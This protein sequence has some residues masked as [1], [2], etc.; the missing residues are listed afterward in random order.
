ML[1]SKLKSLPLAALAAALFLLPA[2]RAEAWQYV[3]LENRGAFLASLIVVYG[4]DERRDNRLPNWAETWT[5]DAIGGASA[6]R[7][8]GDEILTH[9]FP[10]MTHPAKVEGFVHDVV[11]DGLVRTARAGFP[12]LQW[13]CVDISALAE[14]E[15][16]YVVASTGEI[17]FP[18]HN[19]NWT[20]CDTHESNPRPF[21]RQQQ[22]PYNEIW[23]TAHGILGHPWCVYSKEIRPRPR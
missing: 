4:F 15:R 20:V 17:A 23:F 21:Y 6:T 3:C 16:F 22:R 1:I 18:P 7:H 19:G 11:A 2:P 5:M 14:G 13:R 9:K 8:W 12:V 10:D